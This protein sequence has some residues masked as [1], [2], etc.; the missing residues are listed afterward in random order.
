MS[1]KGKKNKGNDKGKKRTRKNKKKKEKKN[2]TELVL[3]E[4]SNHPS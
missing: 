2:P 4:D 3:L 1:D